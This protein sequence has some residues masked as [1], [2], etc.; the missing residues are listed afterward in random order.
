MRIEWQA[1]YNRRGSI[2]RIFSR[3]KSHRRLNN[4]T[5]RRGYKVNVHCF[6]SLIVVQAK[7][8]HSAMSN[9]IFSVRQC[10]CAIA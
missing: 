10:V 7:A 6:L 4:I 5:V 1:I 8:L 3:L 9:Q 2:E